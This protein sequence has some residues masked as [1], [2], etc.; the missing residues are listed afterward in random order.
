MAS[1]EMASTLPGNTKQAECAKA[2]DWQLTLNEIEKWPN[3]K[4]Y[5]ESLKSLT[6]GIACQEEA[7]TTGHKHIHIYTQ[8]KNTI[9]LSIKKCC[10]A[11]IEKCLG[12]PQQNKAYIEKDG[13]I[14]WEYGNMRKN[15]G[16]HTIGE[17]KAM[18]IEER[19]E[20]PIQY[21]NIVEKLNRKDAEKQTFMEMLKEIKENKLKGPEVIY[22]TGK[23][24]KGKTYHGY[25]IAIDKFPLEKIGKITIENNFFSIVNEEAECFIIEEFRASQLHASAFLQLTDKYGYNAN[26]KG[27]FVML[28]PKCLIICSIIRPT[29]LYINEEVNKQFLRR[30]TQ[31][32]DMNGDELQESSIEISDL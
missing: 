29:E 9:K 21:A 30:I 15:G 18:N 22:I 27:G 7:P 5:L 2:R 4:A 13:N 19:N 17:V 16:Y 3:L 31:T 6:F 8:F 10:G 1:C 23:T 32:I 26:T 28:R 24:G 11:H 14:I 25:Q 12:T 20:L